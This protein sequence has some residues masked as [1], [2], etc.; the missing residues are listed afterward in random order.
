MK[1]MCMFCGKNHPQGSKEEC[2]FKGS[3]MVGLL[4]SLVDK[5]QWMAMYLCDKTPLLTVAW[6][7][8]KKRQTKRK[9]R[10]A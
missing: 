9:R 3:V 2:D 10:S 8:F 5:E 7:S 6:D 1:S 4:A